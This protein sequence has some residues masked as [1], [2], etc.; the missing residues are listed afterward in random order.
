MFCF[1][2]KTEGK[3]KVKEDE[4]DEKNGSYVNGSST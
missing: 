4:E 3:K 1:A 2:N